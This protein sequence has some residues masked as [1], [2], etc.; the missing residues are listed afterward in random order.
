M[1]NQ[2]KARNIIERTVLGRQ[3]TAPRTALAIT[4]ALADAGLIRP[5][6]MHQ[7]QRGNLLA[8]GSLVTYTRWVTDWEVVA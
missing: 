4:Q 2:E 1:N 5:D 3:T 6:N 7:E 8:D